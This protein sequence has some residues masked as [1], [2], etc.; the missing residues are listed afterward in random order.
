MVISIRFADICVMTLNGFYSG[1]DIVL[2][3]NVLQV[4]ALSQYFLYLKAWI[5]LVSFSFSLLLIFVVLDGWKHVMTR[6]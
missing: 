2:I 5:T 1:R 4:V 3:S 6:C